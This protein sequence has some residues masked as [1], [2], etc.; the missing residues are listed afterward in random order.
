MI[1][2]LPQVGNDSGMAIP[3]PAIRSAQTSSNATRSNA[4]DNCP[5]DR[6]DERLDLVASVMT[7]LWMGSFRWVSGRP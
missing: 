2:K 7:G 1:E 6:L 5:D 3:N 4:R